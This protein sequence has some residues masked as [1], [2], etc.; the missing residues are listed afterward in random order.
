MICKFCGAEIPAGAYKCDM[1]GQNIH[2]KKTPSEGGMFGDVLMTAQTEYKSVP[3]KEPSKLPKIIA[4]SVA[5]LVVIAGIVIAL[6]IFLKPK[7]EIDQFIDSFFNT[8]ALDSMEISLNTTKDGFEVKSTGYYVFDSKA[9]E[10]RLFLIDEKK[11]DIKMYIFTPAASYLVKQVSQEVYS[12]KNGGTRY[13]GDEFAT[14]YGDAYFYLLERNLETGPSIY[15]AIMA[16][17]KDDHDAFYTALTKLTGQY[18]DTNTADQNRQAVDTVKKAFETI[19]TDL[20]DEDKQKSVFG[21]TMTKANSTLNCKFE[22]EFASI[23]TYGLT[24]AGGA[25]DEQTAQ[26][27]L[28]FQQLAALSPNK[29]SISLDLSVSG[30]KIRNGNFSMTAQGEASVTSFSILNMNK[31]DIPARADEFYKAYT[32]SK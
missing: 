31:T 17:R 2:S 22:P 23:F 9:K 15:E 12:Q 30:G 13:E 6:M 32:K 14:Y 18:K 20:K 19:K 5:A 8:G 26:M 1:C 29:P 28:M 3:M 7:K 11:E 10:I 21:F 4:I 25:L 24:I 27:L 16:M